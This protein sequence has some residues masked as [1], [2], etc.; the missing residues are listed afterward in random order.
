MI[1]R[2]T[3]ERIKD[4]ANIVEVV[5][6]F[7]TLRRAGANYKGLC[8]FHNEKTPSFIVSPARGT[9]HCFGCGRGGNAVSFIMEHEQFTYPEALRWLAAKYGIEVVEKELTD[10][11][12][13]EQSQREAMY[14]INEWARQYFEDTLHTHAD[15]QAV[16]MQYLRGRGFRD[17][18]IAAYHLGFSLRD[19]RAL[20]QRAIKEG[21]KEEYLLL[22]GLCYKTDRGELI[23]RFAD[24][25]VFPWIGLNGK[26]VGFSARLL[27]SRTKG[28]QQKYVNSPDSEVYHKERELFGIFQAKKSIARDDRVYIVEGQTDVLSMAQTGIENVV[29]NSGTALSTHQINI[30]HRFT[31]NITLLYDN[32]DAGIHAAMRGTD[33]LLAEGMNVKVLLL[34]EGDDPDSFARKHSADEF[35]EYVESHQMDFIQFKTRHLLAHAAD[36]QQRTEAI[37]SIV[38]SIAGVPNQV[39]RDTYLH[40][41]AAAV[42]I[43]EATLINR[44]NTI[45]RER[46][47]GTTAPVVSVPAATATPAQQVERMLAQLV[48][49]YGEQ[50]VL[51]NVA[52]E[53]GQTVDVTLAQYVCEMLHAEDLLLTNRLYQTILDS[54]AQIAPG[55]ATVEQTL[56][57]DDD[58]ELSR[59]ALDLATDKYSTVPMYA[60]PN[61][62]IVDE[63]YE[64]EKLM[65]HLRSEAEHLIADYRTYCS[66]E[67]LAAVKAQLTNSALSEEEKKALWVEYKRLLDECNRVA[68]PRRHKGDEPQAGYYRKILRFT[69]P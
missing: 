40:D 28:V 6:E 50:L 3:V 37:D 38:R 8:P 13:Q 66:E 60:T 61:G 55:G 46:L 51:R 53:H 21:Y 33:M 31:D 39:L 54:A 9:C 29:A 62:T 41:A 47:P 42:G 65:D 23:D 69:L 43:K 20:P 7:V 17:D 58:L 2:T 35:R 57:H 14:I 44:M 16:G 52:D 10:K 25:V 32:D 63:E 26:V 4:A 18:I 19:R 59:V 67:K 34:P 68:D 49:R 30:L 27:D 15:G 1:D 45:I 12:R 5:S 24:R 11:E 36:P 22:T 56:V 64:K 48:V